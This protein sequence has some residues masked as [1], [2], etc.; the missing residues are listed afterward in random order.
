MTAK[1]E[2]I[3]LEIVTNADELTVLMDNLNAALEALR[4]FHIACEIKP[5]DK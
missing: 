4:Q 5:K 1:L 2:Q 3:E